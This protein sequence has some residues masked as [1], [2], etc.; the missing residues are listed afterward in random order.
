[1][2][3]QIR[4]LAVATD[5]WCDENHIDATGWGAVA[6]EAKFAELI[7]QACAKHIKDQQDLVETNWQ[8]KDGV[9][10]VYNLKEHFGV[11]NDCA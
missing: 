3:Q 6:W 10:I 11:E 2:N 8:C 1:M 4:T 9:H 5:A 7:V